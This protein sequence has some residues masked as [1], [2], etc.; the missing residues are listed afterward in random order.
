MTKHYRT[1]IFEFV[2]GSIGC[3]FTSNSMVSFNRYLNGNENVEA[4][5]IL[6]HF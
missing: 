2:V 1:F 3:V 6:G 4:D 5:L